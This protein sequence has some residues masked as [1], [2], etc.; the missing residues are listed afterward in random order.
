MDQQVKTHSPASTVVR[1][2]NQRLDNLGVVAS[3]SD[4]NQEIPIGQPYGM[5]PVGT[6]V[7]WSGSTH[8][9][10]SGWKLC[11]GKFYKTG[12]SPQGLNDVTVP[13][14]PNADRSA[15]V[16]HMIFDEKWYFAPDLE[17]RFIRGAIVC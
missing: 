15:K 2:I 10:P 12:Q 6:I 9:L 14:N 17:N 11:D 4:D 8:D 3:S 7:M 5:V 16:R 1:V 13:N